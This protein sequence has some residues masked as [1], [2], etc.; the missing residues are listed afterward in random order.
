[1]YKMGSKLDHVYRS[2]LL[3][4][5]FTRGWGHPDHLIK[6]IRLRK[7][8]GNRTTAQELLSKNTT[9]ITITKEEKQD[10]AILL[11]GK[12][13]QDTSSLLLWIFFQKFVQQRYKKHTF[14]QFFPEI[15]LK[16]Q[17]L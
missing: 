10:D 11:T 3:T 14:R 8:L 4:K 5:F 12:E 1:M 2:L 9:S 13:T 15:L 7:L 17:N 16:G 6:I